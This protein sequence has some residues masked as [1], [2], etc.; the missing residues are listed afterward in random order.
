[1]SKAPIMRTNNQKSQAALQHNTNLHESDDR[2][3]ITDCIDRCRKLIV[4]GHK[5]RERNAGA[6][7]QSAGE[8]SGREIHHRRTRAGSHKH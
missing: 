1:M 6:G 4:G 8:L 5:Q 3:R 2:R 7:G